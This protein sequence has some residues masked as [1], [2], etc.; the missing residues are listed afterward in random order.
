MLVAICGLVD[1][2]TPLWTVAAESEGIWD[3]MATLWIEEGRDVSGTL[4][5]KASGFIFSSHSNSSTGALPGVLPQ[6]VANCG[7]SSDSTVAILLRRIK[8]NAK[9]A[10]PDWP[11]FAQDCQHLMIQLPR[12]R[13]D[14]PGCAILRHS[15]LS[16]PTFAAVMVGVLSALLAVKTSQSLRTKALLLP[17]LAIARHFGIKGYDC[18]TQLTGT[19]IVS[20]IV[21]SA[22]IFGS[23]ED[24]V[25][26][27]HNLLQTIIS[28]F[29][30]Y[31]PVLFATVDHFPLYCDF[32]TKKLSGRIRQDI[33]A[34]DSRVNDY[35]EISEMQIQHSFDCGFPQ[36]RLVYCDLSTLFSYFLKCPVTDSECTF[37]RCSGCNF[38]LYCSKRCQKK[39]WREQHKVLCLEMCSSSRG[40][41]SLLHA[42]SIVHDS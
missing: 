36:V 39:H 13:P 5:F 34:L 27:S 19:N 2:P 4:G 18:V 41:L 12:E 24:V 20:I 15:L 16:H 33:L 17:L 37:R 28:R 1:I 31:R 7:G 14:T 6:I 35:L 11:S 8:I 21:G 32:M 9:Q 42:L 29:T 26:I 40:Q 23:D 38:I 10:E 25:E 3:M 22:Q 30:I